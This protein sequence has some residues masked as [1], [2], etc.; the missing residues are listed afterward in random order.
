M[1]PSTPVLFFQLLQEP[2]NTQVPSPLE[3]VMKTL[4]GLSLPTQF[5]FL[6]ANW[7]NSEES[8]PTMHAAC[9]QETE[10]PSTS[11]KSLPNAVMELLKEMRSAMLDLRTLTSLLTHAEETADSQDAVMV[12]RTR[13]NNVMELPTA[14]KPAHSAV[15]LEAMP[16]VLEQPPEQIPMRS[17]STL[18]KFLQIN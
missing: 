8:S 15:L 18:L 3:T 16:P 12:F 6:P 10:D 11:L 4:I 7:P 9:K 2:S 1:S 14:L 13:V 17:T 5:Q